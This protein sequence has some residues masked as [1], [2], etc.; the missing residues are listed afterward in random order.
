MLTKQF[1]VTYKMKLTI[2]I[3]STIQYFFQF[4]PRPKLN[5]HYPRS[6]VSKTG[7][8]TSFWL[9]VVVCGG[10]LFK[11]KFTSV[12]ESQGEIK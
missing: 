9:F 4:I 7:S 3:N 1:K 5:F 10:S 12:F 6:G 11:E 8:K 2:N